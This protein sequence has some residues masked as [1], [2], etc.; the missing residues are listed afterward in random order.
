MWQII[1]EYIKVLITVI[2]ILIFAL[3]VLNEEKLLLKKKTIIS[4]FIFSIIYTIL[5]LNLTG[6]IK[7][8]LMGVSS[9]LYY[10]Y[11][12][13]ISYKKSILLTFLDM[14]TVLPVD[15]L[16]L[17][18]VNKIL[19][20]S[21]EESYNNFAGTMVGNISTFILIVIITYLFRK[22]FRKLIKTE[23]DNNI[24]IIIFSILIFIC[25]GMLF[26]TIIKEFKLGE[27]I[28]LYLIAIIVLLLVLFSLIKQTI[29]NKK[30]M[31]KYD[32]LLEFMT[33]YEQEIEKI[34]V[35]RHETKNEFLAIKSKIVDKQKEEEII[36]YIND[37]IKDDYEI[38]NEMYAKF[39]YL[40]ANGIK[41]LCYFKTQEAESK[42][43]KT[44]INVSPRVEKSF[45]SKLNT[46]QNRDLGKI[47][48]VLLDNA[49]EGSLESVEKQ[50]GIE[51]YFSLKNE[52]EFIICNTCDK[53]IDITKNG[54]ESFS[55]KGK[56][57][58]H[59]LMLVNHI[60][61]NNDIFSL[62]TKVI[63]GIYIQSLKIKK[64]T[65]KK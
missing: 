24:K 46:K 48:G 19:K 55:T 3:I 39:G 50:F 62:D 7:S 51:V 30:I 29:E 14:V 23:I 20:F 56:N 65:S 28:I 40:P 12:F 21:L 61:K 31:S 13:S 41:G 64:P 32:K 54:K 34:R 5:Y 16:E 9:V 11:T 35:L 33:S 22:I 44:A 63:K 59:G 43:L 49:I 45:L 18:F 37:I 6:T 47:L 53:E 25:I 10:S 57:R 17:L 26:Y 15:L 60:I 8:F 42:G 36:K 58:G 1:S 52:C 4:T 38:K 27:N 2:G